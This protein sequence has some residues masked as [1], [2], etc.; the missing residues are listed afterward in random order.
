MLSTDTPTGRLNKLFA[1]ANALFPEAVP[2]LDFL[3][4]SEYSIRPTRMTCATRYIS[5][6][7]SAFPRS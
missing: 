3:D 5:V 4:D 7:K 2:E 6:H 1:L